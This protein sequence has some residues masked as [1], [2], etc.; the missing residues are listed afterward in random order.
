MCIYILYIYR[1]CIHTRACLMSTRTPFH[2]PLPFHPNLEFFIPQLPSAYCFTFYV[3]LLRQVQLWACGRAAYKGA[4][5]YDIALAIGRFL[6]IVS[7]MKKATK[8]IYADLCWSWCRG[9]AAQG[10]FTWHCRKCGCCQ[11]WREWHCKRYNKCVYGVSIPCETCR[12]LGF[13]KR[14]R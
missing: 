12:P 6:L 4:N 2:L 10:T 7:V 14:M 11:D 3:S 13:A 5:G 1:L 8:G 9:E